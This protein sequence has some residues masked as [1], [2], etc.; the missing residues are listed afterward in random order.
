MIIIHWVL[1]FV[2]L[3]NNYLANIKQYQIFILLITRKKKCK[4]SVTDNIANV[5]H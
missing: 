2:R 4:V 3:I 5:R 1:H